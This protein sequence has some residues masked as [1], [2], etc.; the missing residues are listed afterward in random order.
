MHHLYSVVCGRNAFGR[1]A[2]MT[3][4][5]SSDVYTASIVLQEGD[6]TL[7][8]RI[9]IKAGNEHENS[10]VLAELEKHNDKQKHQIG[11]KCLPES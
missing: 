3:H 5:H 1:E 8:D 2:L 11:M 6:I 4:T 9:N 7:A 10:I